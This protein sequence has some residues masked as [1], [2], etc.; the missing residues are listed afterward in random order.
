MKN[1]SIYEKNWL[2]LVFEGKNKEYG[3]YQLRQETGKTSS[4]AF[5]VGSLF[6]ASV[7]LLLSSFTEK[8]NPDSN[9]SLDGEV[10]IEKVYVAPAIEKSKPKTEQPK[11][12]ETIS[13]A[14]D[15][16]FPNAPMVVAPTIQA[17]I[18][19]P[20]NANLNTTPIDVNGNPNGTLPA[21]STN[22]NSGSG[23]STI[24][25][26]SNSP[27]STKEL[28]RQPN[29]PGGI[30]N[31]YQYVGENFDKENIEGETVR[32]EVSFIIE[33]N[34]TMSDI[35]VLRKTNSSVD[36]E[37]IRV[38][39]SLRTKWSPGYKDGQPVRTQFTLPISVVL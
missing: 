33:K 37:A 28:D 2:D 24:A 7:I 29:F 38:L 34:G 22:T 15:K 8:P 5:V 9:K 3:A 19:V 1:V 17:V 21:T 13:N 27:V 31:F 39:K 4:I 6:L 14:I 35:K 30:Q 23:T 11:A 10:I 26:N 12:P 32:V 20:T 16:I 36:K 18:D 25:I